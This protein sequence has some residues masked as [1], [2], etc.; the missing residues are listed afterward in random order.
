MSK[1]LF[2][3]SKFGKLI[4]SHNIIAFRRRQLELPLKFR[5]RH[6]LG[7]VAVAATYESCIHNL[8]TA[9]YLVPDKTYEESRRRTSFGYVNN[10]LD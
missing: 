3:S 6:M 2:Q 9:F 4:N 7:W 10:V 5:V 8:Y 1:S